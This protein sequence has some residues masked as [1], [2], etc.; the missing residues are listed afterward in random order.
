MVCSREE[1]YQALAILKKEC[2]S[3]SS[4]QQCPLSK[5][6]ICIVQDK[7]PVDYPIHNPNNETYRAFD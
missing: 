7:A 5:D 4:C 3:H 2:K 1:L 6:G